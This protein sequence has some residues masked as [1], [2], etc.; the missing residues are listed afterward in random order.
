MLSLKL[1]SGFHSFPAGCL[2]SFLC[3]EVGQIWLGSNRPEGLGQMAGSGSHVLS[4]CMEAKSKVKGCQNA[5]LSQSPRQERAGGWRQVAGIACGWKSQCKLKQ[6][7]ATRKMIILV[8]SQ[9]MNSY[10]P[11]KFKKP[12]QKGHPVTHQGFSFF[13]CFLLSLPNKGVAKIIS[14]LWVLLFSC[15]DIIE[16]YV[17]R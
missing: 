17:E 16:K 13:T 6:A 10:C 1:S 14:L 9:N 15:C 8:S 5:Q 12:G 7:P 4:P 11:L 2:I 3:R